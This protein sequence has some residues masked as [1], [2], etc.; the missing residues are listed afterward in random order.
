VTA[1]SW[2]RTPVGGILPRGWKTFG[3][4]CWLLLV[5]LVLPM[6][7][8]PV[9]GASM[10]PTLSDGQVLAYHTLA[11]QLLG[12][13]RGEIVVFR[14]PLD[15]SHH[16]VKRVVGL[17]GDELL[18]DD[19]HLFVNDVELDLPPS[20]VEPGFRLVTRVPADCFFALG[21][22]A[23]VSMDSRRFGAVP[24]ENLLGR[25]IGPFRHAGGVP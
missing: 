9:R 6:R 20:S 2:W 3:A 10:E 1:G 17:P 7:I 16:F 18:F 25:V 13:D 19:G 8:A 5:L 14:S 11:P 15:R 12:L 21:D 4:A 22:H 24:M 23:S